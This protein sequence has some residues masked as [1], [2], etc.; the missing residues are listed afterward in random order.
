AGPVRRADSTTIWLRGGDDL[1]VTRLELLA[2]ITDAL[3][4][5]PPETLR[6]GLCHDL[7]T[8]HEHLHE[9]MQGTN[10]HD[11]TPTEQR[12]P[13]PIARTACALFAR[14]KAGLEGAP[15]IAP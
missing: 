12:Q 15:L 13:G 9:K 8:T 10:T 5:P 2:D 7:R 4:R 1:L 3:L 6:D 14:A 11:A